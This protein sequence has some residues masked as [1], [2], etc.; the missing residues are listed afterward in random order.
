M[1]Q[2]GRS[3]SVEV[4]AKVN[5]GLQIVEKRPDG[6]HNL[7]TIFYPTDFFH[8]LMT[9]RRV[10][11]DFTL[12]VD[13]T[14]DIG[15]VESNLCTKAF[16]LLQKDFGISGVEI[17]LRKGI[18][19][20][21]GLGGGSADAAA[22]LRLLDD[23]FC[24]SI[25][26]NRMQEYALQLGSDVPFFILNEPVYATG[27]G[28]IM[29]PVSLDLSAYKL[30]IVKPEISISTREAYGGVTP[31]L[32]SISLVEAVKRPVEKWKN[33]I[34]NDFEERLFEKYPL[35]AETKQKLYDEGAVYASMSGSGSACFGLF[36]A[37]S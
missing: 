11:G 29:T 34:V 17:S 2:T 9:V 23:L 18:P 20:G 3:I 1:T 27:R 21:A 36:N 26:M 35:L 8:D 25:P 19:S 37:A 32:P 13:S 33:L 28:E 14:E 5:I 6:Y 7:Q 24:L 12:N 4:N 30:K 10:A 31:K 16:R 22:T 15:D